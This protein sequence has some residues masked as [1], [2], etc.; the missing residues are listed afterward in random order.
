MSVL[1]IPGTRYVEERIS[2]SL[3]E[4][5]AAVVA[6]E[7]DA[8]ICLC[9]RRMQ[10]NGFSTQSVMDTPARGRRVLVHIR[11]QVYRC[12]LKTKGCSTIMHPI[13]GVRPNAQI[14]DDL[15]R[16]IVVDAI[17]DT[18]AGVAERYGVDPST[19]AEIFSQ[20]VQ[21]RLAARDWTPRVVGID[22]VM[23]SGGYRCVLT[24]VEAHRPVDLLL[25][26]DAEHVT[27]ALRRL[28]DVV[29][30]SIDM[31]DNFYTSIRKVRPSAKI[32]ADRFHVIKYSGDVLAEFR[33]ECLARAKTDKTYIVPAGM[34]DGTFYKWIKP[35][36]ENAAK[37]ADWLEKYPLMRELDEARKAFAEVYMKSCKASADRHLRQ[38]VR[39]LSTFAAEA[40]AALVKQLSRTDCDW[41]GAI[42]NFYDF[43]VTAGYTERMNGLLKLIN[44]R[45][46]GY[47]FDALRLKFVTIHER[48]KFGNVRRHSMKRSSRRPSEPMAA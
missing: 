17:F 5:K 10:R 3:I 14:T 18:F 34:T 4:C 41:R 43:K 8:P 40:F 9:G 2:A 1:F 16:M 33:R 15:R 38:W 27:D 30:F 23:I 22:E 28:D 31:S 25:K 26:H 6:D 24:D 45:G 32:I 47:Q 39:N 42:L 29:A 35:L 12:A 7:Q 11:R 21:R 13:E 19:V 46:Y 36:P 44:L 20:D 48:P 37:V